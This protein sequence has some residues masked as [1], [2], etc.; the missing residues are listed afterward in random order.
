MTDFLAFAGRLIRNT[1]ARTA[2]VSEEEYLS[3]AT[4]RIDLELKMRE[5][6]RMR[7]NRQVYLGG[8]ATL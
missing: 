8:S 6:D 1:M 2:I 4:D 3:D 7:G 5:Y